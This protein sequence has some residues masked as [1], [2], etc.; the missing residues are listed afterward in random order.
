ML[1]IKP[2]V[3]PDQSGVTGLQEQPEAAVKPRWMHGRAREAEICP[4]TDILVYTEPGQAPDG[5]HR[6]GPSDGA[7]KRCKAEGGAVHRPADRRGRDRRTGRE[8]AARRIRF[9][10]GG[11]GILAP[12]RSGAGPAGA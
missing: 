2:P 4:F 5:C 11:P 8:S 6:M 3:K 10:D 12:C 1:T 9:A 7:C